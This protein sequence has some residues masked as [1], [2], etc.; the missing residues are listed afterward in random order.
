MKNYKY[1]LY[2]ILGVLLFVISFYSYA[3]AFGYTTMVA[4]KPG[5]ALPADF[6]KAWKEATASLE[7]SF[8]CKISANS[9]K[10]QNADLSQ[11]QKK[12]IAVLSKA[13]GRYKND[14]MGMLS[15]SKKQLY[16]SQS[17]FNSLGALDALAA[18]NLLTPAQAEIALKGV[19]KKIAE[20]ILDGTKVYIKIDNGWETFEDPDFANQLYS[21]VTSDSLVTALEKNSFIL[22]NPASKTT[23]GVY[24][25]TLTSASTI[26]LL[27]PFMGAE[28]AK[29]QALAPVKLL[30]SKD[31]HI[32]SFDTTDKINLG[33]LSFT[34]KQACTTNFATPK[35]KIPAGSKT[36]SKEKALQKIASVE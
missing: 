18:Q 14:S 20:I 30:I 28:N 25:G 9:V 17:K 4:A 13:I 3:R 22:K 19:S 7:Y 26:A 33:G 6:E 10:A 12:L 5:T 27:T 21:G 15:D 23:A 1:W 16:S 8:A 31:A 32:K 36:I 34:V 35:I 11:D 24:E 29:Q 2:P